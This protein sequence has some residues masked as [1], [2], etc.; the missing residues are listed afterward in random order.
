MRSKLARSM[1]LGRS[2]APAE[3]PIPASRRRPAEKQLLR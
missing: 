3:G 1:R 2:A